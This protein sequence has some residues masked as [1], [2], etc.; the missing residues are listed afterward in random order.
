MNDTIIIP[1][2]KRI[3]MGDFII[4]ATTLIMTTIMIFVLAFDATERMSTRA[5]VLLT[6]G[7][8]IAAPVAWYYIVF[9]FV[10]FA[11]S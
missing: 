7:A 10:L 1:Q 2:A 11:I 3:F 8:V 6:T 4:L 9:P 5:N